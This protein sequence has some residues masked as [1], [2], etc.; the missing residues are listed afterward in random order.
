MSRRDSEGS[1]PTTLIHNVT[2]SVI[3]HV[4]GVLGEFESNDSS[5]NASR[6]LDYSQNQGEAPK[7]GNAAAPKK[8]AAA[9]PKNTS[10]A[11][12]AKEKKQ[13]QQE[14]D[15]QREEQLKAEEARKERERQEQLQQQQ[16][17]E[18]EENG[19][20]TELTE[21]DETKSSYE[22]IM[23]ARKV[24]RIF[25]VSLTFKVCMLIISACVMGFAAESTPNIDIFNCNYDHR[26]GF[27]AFFIVVHAFFFCVMVFLMAYQLFYQLKEKARVP[28]RVMDLLSLVILI[29]ICSI[30]LACYALWFDDTLDPY[31]QSCQERPLP[32]KDCIS[33]QTCNMFSTM[34]T[35]AIGAMFFGGLLVFFLILGAILLGCVIGKKMMDSPEGQAFY[36]KMQDDSDLSVED[37]V[38]NANENSNIKPLT[39]QEYE[40]RELGYGGE[41][42]VL[43]N[44]DQLRATKSEKRSETPLP[45]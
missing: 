17:P 43:L 33:E 34:R 29:I 44:F 19:E 11:A 5:Q 12:D 32:V 24:K 27:V 20:D 7:K 41:G 9:A 39:Q 25:V 1:L 3:G 6:D 28:Q 30:S 45:H 38:K 16:Q 42:L 15:R 26:P 13:Q 22:I 35:M 40:D 18:D 37:K 31:Y 2:H 23:Y 21:S 8:A 4:S 10:A 14:A 36:K